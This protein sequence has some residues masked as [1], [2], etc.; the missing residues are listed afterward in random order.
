MLQ[1]ADHL[2]RIKLRGTVK[3]FS[4]VKKFGFISKGDGE[5][6]F[7]RIKEKYIKALEN[8]IQLFEIYLS[9]EKDTRN[10]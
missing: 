10:K 8:N 3:W 7:E 4:T 9:D 6:I 1:V 2:L 5:D